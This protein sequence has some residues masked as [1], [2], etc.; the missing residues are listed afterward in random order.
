MHTV[1]R[2]NRRELMSPRT[3][4]ERKEQYTKELELEVM[5]LKELFV[6]TTRE[7]D[8][9]IQS[10]DAAM[11]ERDRLREENLRLR[12]HVQPAAATSSAGTDS[13]YESMSWTCDATRANSFSDASGF[14]SMTA[15][16]P[17]QEVA[18]RA[19]LA[20]THR[21][22]IWDTEETRGFAS[23]GPLLD[24]PTSQTIMACQR[25][26]IST[27]PVTVKLAQELPAVELDYD[28][29]GLDFILT[30]VTA[31]LV[32]E[33]VLTAS[34]DSKDHVWV[35]YITC[36]CERT[37]IRR[38]RT[39]GWLDNPWKCPTTERTSTYLVTP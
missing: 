27:A 24:V 1:Q 37:I 22:S 3:H 11:L 17:L 7:R 10:R 21:L 39:A 5:R 13:G 32:H 38:P 2:K 6:Q 35:T 30:C 36:T 34:I 14:P 12:E 26:S 25:S 9:A 4:R 16:A 15:N 23:D 19:P 31:F 8:D 33:I 18:D 28:E 29:L 20:S